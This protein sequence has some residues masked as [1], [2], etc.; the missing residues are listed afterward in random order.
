MPT[1]MRNPQS[2]ELF[3]ID[4]PEAM[5][6]G[7]REPTEEER[8]QY[9]KT[10]EYGTA[11]QQALAQ[12]ERVV[13]GATFGTVEGFGD[14]KDIRARADVSREQSPVTSFVADVAPDIA[15]GLATGG[16]GALLTASGRAAAR[17][18]TRGALSAAARA[19]PKAALAGEAIGSGAVAASQ[20]AYEQGHAFLSGEHL[21]DDLES[22]A[23][24][25]GLGFAAGGAMHAIGN[26]RSAWKAR[27]AAS[28]T[29]KAEVEAGEQALDDIARTS[30]ESAQTG[31]PSSDAAAPTVAEYVAPSVS[32][33]AATPITPDRTV[34]VGGPDAIAPAPT[35]AVETPEQ[36]LARMRAL[37]IRTSDGRPLADVLDDEL[38]IGPIQPQQVKGVQGPEIAESAA[39]EALERLR[40]LGV[41][42]PDGRGLADAIEDGL[43]RLESAGVV[44]RKGKAGQRTIGWRM[45]ADEY[46]RK[47]KTRGQAPSEG[48]LAAPGTP[49][50]F[51][52]LTQT[53]G[54]GIPGTSTAERAA[55]GRGMVNRT[56][57]TVPPPRR[58]AARAAEP[59]PEAMA[60][61]EIDPPRGTQPEDIPSDFSFDDAPPYKPMQE[62][63]PG[64]RRMAHPQYGEGLYGQQADGTWMV[65]DDQVGDAFPIEGTPKPITRK[66]RA[67]EGAS[68]LKSEAVAAPEGAAIPAAPRGPLTRPEV[69]SSPAQLTA[70]DIEGAIE[71][72]RGFHGKKKFINSVY[73]D[74]KAAGGKLDRGNFDRALVKLHLQ[75]VVDLSRADLVSVMDPGDVAGSLI[76]YEGARFN[77]VRKGADWD[78]ATAGPTNVAGSDPKAMIRQAAFELG[79]NQTKQRVFIGDIR[80]KTGMSADEL[81]ENLRQMQRDGDLVLY[82]DD[83]AEMKTGRGEELESMTVGDSPRHI[84]YLEKA[85]VEQPAV[86]D[87]PSALSTLVSR[88][89]KG[90]LLPVRELRE[91]VP[92]MSKEQFDDAVLQMEKRGEVT[93]HHHDMAEGISKAERDQLVTDGKTYYVGIVP[94]E[95]FN[96]RGSDAL[97][98]GATVGLSQLESDDEMAMASA[99]MLPFLAVLFR[100]RVFGRFGRRAADRAVPKAFSRATQNAARHEA[101]DLLERAFRKADPEDRVVR[102]ATPIETEAQTFGRQRR[103]HGYRKEILEVA[104]REVQQD[105][106]KAVKLAKKLTDIKEMKSADIAKNIAKNP[107]AQQKM[108]DEVAGEAA[109]LVGRLRGEAKQY[110]RNAARALGQNPQSAKLRFPTESHK[111]LALAAMDHAKIINKAVAKGDGTEIYKA[112]DNFK[113]TLDDIKVSIERGAGSSDNPIHH[114]ALAPRVAEFADKLRGQMED[115]KVWGRLG[116]MQREYNAIWHD[117]FFPA[118]KTFEQT[119][120]KKTHL[121]YDGIWEVEGWEPKIRSFLSSQDPGKLRHVEGML[122]AMREMAETR[123]KYG[124]AEMSLVNNLAERVDRVR[125]AIGLMDEVG[126]ATKK[127]SDV[128]ELT[129]SVLSPLGYIGGGFAGG[130]PG[131]FMGGAMVRAGREFATGGLS[132]AIR[133]LRGARD[134]AIE[135]S[136]DDWLMSSR[137]RGGE[138]PKVFRSAKESR[139]AGVAARRGVTISLAAFMG[140]NDSLLD[141]FEERK[142]ELEDEQAFFDRVT[143]DFSEVMPEDPVFATLASSHAAKVRSFLIDRAPAS[144]A[145]S[146]G[147]PMGLP[148]DQYSIEDWAEYWYTAFHPLEVV[149]DVGSIG[150]QQIETLMALYP[151]TYDALQTTVLEKLSQIKSTGGEIDDN[152]AMRMDIL[153]QLDGSMST[154]FSRAVAQTVAMATQQEAQQQSRGGGGSS[155]RVERLSLFNPGTE[156]PTMGGGR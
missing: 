58:G 142:A 107:G 68:A 22:F 7:W 41:S 67:A 84:V 26:A 3:V 44:T 38:A 100:S 154:A 13:R 11:G 18:V 111:S 128:S 117:K 113:R 20:Q 98:L 29:A 106:T 52:Y 73:E 48:S 132:H 152:A 139:W 133:G 137:L 112:L 35:I 87:I 76:E 39:D 50:D 70:R 83:A 31:Y 27:R 49:R 126:E 63:L 64:F 97:A 131:A 10:L 127:M 24:W 144:V 141:A 125:R 77:F 94:K 121:G 91:L 17:G 150:A 93:L 115:A 5:G 42:L 25:A 19:A 71:S 135:R 101:D 69:D 43:D 90:A 54:I 122:D 9:F 45:G 88:N 34:D 146:L 108:A 4:N 33:E 30:E 138:M 37:D 149:Q 14:E 36:A 51:E 95:G 118:A 28:K 116:D 16:G 80:S 8:D 66:A 140:D 124:T 32:D 82:R 56:A 119:V 109:R 105:V 46:L 55:A 62:A 61:T 79:G 153:F 40:Q 2:G 23:A 151:R 103:L 134:A 21:E 65:W 78:K 86:S 110:S 60:P 6:P 145:V 143:A 156:G 136:V 72:A 57:D 47:L 75:G 96:L 1:L 85:P 74:Y 114:E 129:S 92:G 89:P 104:T 147:N 53:E 15:V 99:G 148:P 155:K 120:L 12:G 59:S 130:F 81:H 102:G 123:A